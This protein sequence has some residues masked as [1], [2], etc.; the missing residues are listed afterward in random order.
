MEDFVHLVAELGVDLGNHAIN[1]GFFD[2]LTLVLRFQQFFDKRRYAALGDAIGV[3]FGRESGLRN[4][5]VQNAV[6]SAF[7]VF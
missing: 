5:V 7:I 3:V 1:Q 4:D 6:R 2:R